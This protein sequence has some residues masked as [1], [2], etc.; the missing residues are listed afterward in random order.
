LWVLWGQNYPDK[1]SIFFF[2]SGFKLPSND[3]FK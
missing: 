1:M 2:S 3:D